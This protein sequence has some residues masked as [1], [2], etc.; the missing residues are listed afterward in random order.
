MNTRSIKFAAL[1]AV[2]G[3][4]IV[5]N[6]AASDEPKNFVT[7]G[8]NRNVVGVTPE[9][10][11]LSIP[12]LFRK[13]QNEP[14]CVQATDNP[15]N[16]FCGFNDCRA[17]DWPEVLGDCWIGVG[18]SRDF[19]ETWTSRLAPGYTLHPHSIGMGFAADAAVVEI[20]G[21]SPGLML[22]TYIASFRDSD[23]GVI[24][25]QR[26]V[27]SPLEDGEPYVPV[28]G[29]PTIMTTGSE[30]RFHDKVA[31]IFIP[32]DGVSSTPETVMAEGISQAIDINRLDGCH[33]VAFSVF[34]G[35]GSAVKILTQRSCDGGQTYEKA[36]KA[37][38]E[39]NTVTG[40]HLSYLPDVGLS[41][42]YRRSRDSNEADA[43]MR[44]FSSNL[45]R[46]W[47]KAEVVYEVCPHDQ[48][49]SGSA[50]RIFTFPW[51]A[52]DGER[53]W[54]FSADKVD[55][56]TGLRIAALGQ[57]TQ[58]AGAPP[59]TYPGVSRIVGM[60][61]LNGK[62]WFGSV[63]NADEPFILDLN[64]GV[65]QQVFP[66]AQGVKNRVD[67]AWW[68]TRE[69]EATR[70]PPDGPG[71]ELPLIYDYLTA[72]GSTR[73]FRTANIYMTRINGCK[74]QSAGACT[75]LQPNNDP[76]LV[77]PV[78]ISRYQTFLRD[79][80]VLQEIEANRLN[81][82]TH[83]SGKL[84]YT[85]DYGAMGT[86]RFRRLTSGKVIQNSLP[87]QTGLENFV[88]NE[89]I[90]LAWGDNRDVLFGGAVIDPANPNAQFFYTKPAN[91][92]PAP[93]L[94]APVF[95][96]K[97]ED[98]TDSVETLL[99]EE[100]QDETSLKA[101]N[102]PDDEPGLGLTGDDGGMVC[103]LATNFSRSRDSNVYGSLVEDVPSLIAL[104]QARPM[105]ATQRM[106]PL[107]I[108]NP[109][110]VVADYCLEIFNQAEDAAINAV[111]PP[112]F[113]LVSGS[114]RASF[115]PLPAA[116]DN[117]TGSPVRVR[118][119]VEASKLVGGLKSIALPVRVIE[120]TSSCVQ[121]CSSA[122]CSMWNF[123]LRL[124]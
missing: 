1:V 92:T 114:G 123:W 71:A 95:Q 106:F 103:S 34:T 16:I 39:L 17:S 33:I 53:F 49:A 19:G 124:K 22:L 64:G 60:S 41:L 98:P 115:D 54:V 4:V 91:A 58:V 99:A 42:T 111:V 27:Q 11:Y 86:R 119:D 70:P 38:S 32:D 82:R 25:V 21:N 61:S 89:N 78:R 31:A 40:V 108:N 55:P 85:G 12:D 80:G 24:A 14:S 6:P 36:K 65:G 121:W 104:T 72:G 87:E 105:N 48:Q 83:G 101:V 62:D 43:I 90:F 66:F 9:L 69:D 102:E 76:N 37:S 68:D 8:P 51:G 13:Q 28:D 96:A 120:S 7:P 23:E 46:T 107:V 118:L 20:P 5:N 97:R 88:A 81:L 113:F 18:Q 59:G 74:E 75:P 94:Q 50:A 29:P 67:I 30:G 26:Y 56:D 84:A 2:L 63:G 77:S 117:T 112:S 44:A 52:D 109:G 116:N 100:T 93:V 35:N 79:D 110:T 47:S 73:V 3:F 10:N 57:C 122:V 15:A 45:G